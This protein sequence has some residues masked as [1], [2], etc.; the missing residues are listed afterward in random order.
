MSPTPGACRTLRRPI[1]G[2]I[3]NRVIGRV[4]VDIAAVFE[5]PRALGKRYGHDVGSIAVYPHRL[6]ACVTHQ[7]MAGNYT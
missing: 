4:S 1:K 3:D 5:I 6:H 7:S 2:L